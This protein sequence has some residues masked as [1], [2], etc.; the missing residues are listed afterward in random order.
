MSTSQRASSKPS[1]SLDVI[2]GEHF[3]KEFWQQDDIE[4]INTYTLTSRMQ[5]VI[6]R[7]EPE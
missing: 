1:A 7:P 2:G 6:R 3:T 5:G 4:G